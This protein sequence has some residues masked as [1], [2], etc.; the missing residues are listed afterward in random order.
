M[1]FAFSKLALGD[2]KTGFGFL[3]NQKQVF[4]GIKI[5]FLNLVFIDPKMIFACP[6]TGFKNQCIFHLSDKVKL[7]ANLETKKIKSLVI[8]SLLC[9]RS[10]GSS[11]NLCPQGPRGRKIAWRNLWGEGPG[12][13]VGPKYISRVPTTLYFRVR[14]K[15]K[16]Q[17]VR[18]GKIFP[19]VKAGVRAGRKYDHEESTRVDHEEII[20]AGIHARDLSCTGGKIDVQNGKRGRFSLPL[21]CNFFLNKSLLWEYSFV[22][23]RKN[24]GEVVKCHPRTRTDF[25]FTWGEKNFIVS[26]TFL[27]F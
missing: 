19:C 12:D 24:H 6:N 18:L 4:A 27:S 15:A 9:R 10:L 23:I 13:E 7:H 20:H 1:F 11:Q 25:A 16:T 8:I 2:R 3:S 26:C 5:S 17:R 21:S 22:L 14:R